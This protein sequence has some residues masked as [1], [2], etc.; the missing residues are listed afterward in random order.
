MKTTKNTNQKTSRKGAKAQ[1]KQSTPFPK[2]PLYHHRTNGGA[3]YLT[4][5]FIACAGG[6]KEGIFEGANFIVRIDGDLTKDA[7]LTL[8]G[9]VYA[10]APEL[11]AALL[12]VIDYAETEASQLAEC[13]DCE[14]EAE[15]A[16]KV[17]DLARAAI[18]KATTPGV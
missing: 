15:Q 9:G 5:K 11:L 13:D 4:D 10:A 6:H 14:D 7:S 17:C 8:K 18:A 2:L 3:E 12:A 16:S 1:N